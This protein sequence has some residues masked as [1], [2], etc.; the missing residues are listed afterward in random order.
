MVPAGYWSKA[1]VHCGMFIVNPN[2]F[3]SA[4]KELSVFRDH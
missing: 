1:F 2:I 4:P 3:S